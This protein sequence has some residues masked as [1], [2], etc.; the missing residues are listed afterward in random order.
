MG[1]VATT[2][3]QC[4]RS[5]T[6]CPLTDKVQNPQPALKLLMGSVLQ[7]ESV[8]KPIPLGQYVRPLV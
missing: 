3:N 8:S 1:G 5:T 4:Y 2:Y 6:S 7:P